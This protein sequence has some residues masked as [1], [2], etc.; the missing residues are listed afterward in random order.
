MEITDPEFFAFNPLIAYR[1]RY[2]FEGE[3]SKGEVI[4]VCRT[5]FEIVRKIVGSNYTPTS[6]ERIA[7]LTFDSSS[8]EVF[9]ALIAP[10]PAYSPL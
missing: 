2:S 9:D 7:K 4:A 10:T 5:E 8:A 6:N 1:L 3:T